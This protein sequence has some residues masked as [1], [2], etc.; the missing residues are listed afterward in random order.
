[1][2]LLE[3]RSK[4]VPVTVILLNRS[5]MILH[6]VDWIFA[7]GAENFVGA[8]L[9][10]AARSEYI[11]DMDS[12]HPVNPVGFDASLDGD[13]DAVDD[14]N[15]TLTNLGPNDRGEKHLFSRL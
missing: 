14:H 3:G 1:M 2:L 10:E 8:T 15:N 11:G 12:I 6:H 7:I 4:V 13:R 5:A 9:R